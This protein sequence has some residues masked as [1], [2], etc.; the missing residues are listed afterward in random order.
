MK[1]FLIFFLITFSFSS[2]LIA[3]YTAKY[4]WF[5][6]I[7][8]ASGIFEKNSTDYIIKTNSKLLG[9]AAAL[10]HHLQ[11]SYISIGKIRNGILYP[12]KYITIRKNS[13]KEVKTFYIFHKNYIQKIRF[14]NGKLNTNSTVSYYANQ[15]ILSLYFNLPNFIKD[16]NKTYTFY[17]LGGRHKDGKIEVSFPKGEELKNLKETFDNEKGIYLKANLFNKVFA[18]DKGILYLVINPKNWVTLKGMVKNVLK[19]GDLKGKLVD[20]KQVP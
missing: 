1:K 20:F 8:E 15:D 18:G 16:Y 14:I 12:K 10:S 5:G 9:I 3:T 11:N 7:G 19:I 17:A 13:R 2:T 6:T 4:G